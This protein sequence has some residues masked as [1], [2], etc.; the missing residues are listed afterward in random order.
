MLRSRHTSLLQ[1][2]GRP[3]RPQLRAEQPG[4]VLEPV[5]LLVDASPRVLPTGRARL[6]TIQAS[7]TPATAALAKAAA[8]RRAHAGARTSLPV[9]SGRTE[10]RRRVPLSPDPALLLPGGLAFPG[11][12][13][14]ELLLT[15]LSGGARACARGSV[16]Q[17][18]RRECCWGCDLTRR[19]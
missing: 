8:H 1:V 6:P 18:R 9:S 11:L 19:H 7:G 13:G 5:P 16:S 15:F 3:G 10:G 2:T 4:V 12:K 14:A 17:G